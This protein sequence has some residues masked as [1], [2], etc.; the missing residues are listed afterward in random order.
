[1]GPRQL[2]RMSEWVPGMKSEVPSQ[3][4]YVSMLRQTCWRPH[5]SH[6]LPF[7]ANGSWVLFWVPRTRALFNA[8]TLAMTGPISRN[9]AF[10]V[11]RDFTC[12]PSLDHKGDMVE[13]TDVR[14]LRTVMSHRMM[15]FSSQ[16][17]I[18]TWQTF[19]K[20]VMGLK[21]SHHL[22]AL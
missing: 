12:D 13:Q 22:V 9:S 7:L 11:N 2:C 8:K 3:Q 4:S 14:T 17:Q 20:I 16:L 21:N 10:F 15:W 1:M 5:S 6:S 18:D 19:R